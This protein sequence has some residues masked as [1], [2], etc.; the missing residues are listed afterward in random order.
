MSSLADKKIKF[1][2]VLAVPLGGGGCI[3]L[4]AT[5]RI[6]SLEGSFGQGPA[7]N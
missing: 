1:T 6:D 4:E 7:L 3:G 5:L 2:E